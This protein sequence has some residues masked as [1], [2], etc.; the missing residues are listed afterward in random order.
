MI[1]RMVISRSA[2]NMAAASDAITVSSNVHRSHHLRKN[3]NTNPSP[4]SPKH[5]LKIQNNGNNQPRMRGTHEQPRTG[6][7]ATEFRRR[8]RYRA[9]NPPSI[10]R[11]APV[12]KDESSDSR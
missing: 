6:T 10:G 3:S 5:F 7:L 2:T 4:A 1:F 11:S 12:M 8:M 9:V